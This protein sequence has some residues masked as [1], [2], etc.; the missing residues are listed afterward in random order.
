MPFVSNT[1][2]A[3][4]ELIEAGVIP[5]ECRRFELVAE[6]MK[7]VIMRYEVMAT[8]E[9]M[10]KIADA[11]IRNPEDAREIVRVIAFPRRPGEEEVSVS[12]DI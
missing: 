10:Q 5:Q 11:L 8:E 2:K 12:V 9:Q 1:S 6:P 4:K 7:P 3:I